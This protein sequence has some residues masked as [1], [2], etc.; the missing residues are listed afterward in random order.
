MSSGSR[1]SGPAM[2]P[3]QRAR[4]D[5]PR[6]GLPKYAKRIPVDT[7]S[8][9]LAL[10]GDA[11]APA[12]LEA[13]VLEQLPRVEQVADF[14]CVTTWSFL[15]AGWSGYRFGKLYRQLIEPRIGPGDPVRFIVFRCRDGYRTTLPLEDLMAE[16]VLIADRLGGKP[17]SV[18][19][20]AP[21]RVVAPAHYGYKSAKHLKAIEVWRAE[22]PRK[23]GL[24]YFIDHPR[25]RA[26]REER[27]RVLPGWLL[28]L[29]YRPTIPGGVRRFRAALKEAGTDDS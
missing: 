25:A 7:V 4:S 11:L 20:G 3:G 24:A 19:H 15:D 17:L 26:D 13:A 27:G 8:R 22:P 9:Q 23:T 1:A 2:P 21:L 6:F 5:F 12:T 14:H 16:D 10:G 29:L 18:A 28:R